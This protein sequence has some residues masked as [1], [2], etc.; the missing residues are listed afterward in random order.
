MTVSG[1]PG[2][3]TS[4]LVDLLSKNRGLNSVNGGDIFRQEAQ[5]RKLSVEEYDQ[6]EQ[7]SAE[8]KRQL[9]DREEQVAAVDG[10][11][12][13][14]LELIGSTAIEDKLQDEVKDTLQSLKQAGIKVWVLT[15]DKVE[16]AQNIGLAAGLLDPE[17]EQHVIAY[18]TVGDVL[19]ELETTKKRIKQIAEGTSPLTLK[20]DSVLGADTE[21]VA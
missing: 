9:Q 5:R 1:K 21:D 13:E 7:K 2:S 16:T 12:E 8:A 18:S 4:T 17:M 3:G 15:G 19:G 20:S 6:W 11:I 14:D 10:L